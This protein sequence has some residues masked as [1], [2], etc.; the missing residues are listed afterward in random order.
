M[1]DDGDYD[2]VDDLEDWIDRWEEDLPLR[3]RLRN[4]WLNSR[5]RRLLRRIWYFRDRD[6]LDDIPW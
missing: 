5:L 3:L 1:F 2:D 6:P 4:R